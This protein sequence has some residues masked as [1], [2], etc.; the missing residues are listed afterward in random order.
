[1]FHERRMSVLA[2]LVALVFSGV[3]AAGER[4]AEVRVHGNHSMP[5]AEVIELS[6]IE[7]GAPLADGSVAVIE[8]RLRA[9]ARFESVEVGALRKLRQEVVQRRR[10]QSGE[11]DLKRHRESARFRWDPVERGHESSVPL[12]NPPLGLD[13]DQLTS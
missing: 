5:D 9:S 13:V 8:Q 2:A 11:Q 1:M 6:G 10:T 7:I 12:V 3:A 4:I